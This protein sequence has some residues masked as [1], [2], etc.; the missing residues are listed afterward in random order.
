MKLLNLWF[1]V[2]RACG[3]NLSSHHLLFM[4]EKTG[5]DG[6]FVK[7]IGSNASRRGKP[8]RLSSIFRRHLRTHTKQFFWK[9]LE[10]TGPQLARLYSGSVV[11]QT[12]NSRTGFL[13][14]V[15]AQ[16]F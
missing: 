16:L 8:E 7:L 4:T 10:T 15:L 1:G 13:H 3:Y 5:F 6:L 14:I 12:Y 2:L 9:Y 11:I